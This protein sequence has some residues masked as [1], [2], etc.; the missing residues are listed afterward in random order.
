MRYRDGGDSGE[1]GASDDNDDSGAIGGAYSESDSVL[2]ARTFERKRQT[3]TAR[4]RARTRC[5]GCDD[6]AVK[7]VGRFPTT[8]A[9]L[10]SN[11]PIPFTTL[12]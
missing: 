6:D 3:T 4:S 2:T 9:S 5:G 11:L 12:C 7:A 1:S 10:T 8:A